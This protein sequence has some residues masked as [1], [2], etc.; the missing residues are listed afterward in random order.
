MS[1]LLIVWGAVIVAV[2]HSLELDHW[3]P[4]VV[5]ARAR[6]W[7]TGVTLR[8]AFSG[9]VAHLVSTTLIGLVLILFGE[10]LKKVFEKGLQI[11]IGAVVTLIGLF[12]IQ[13]GFRIFRQKE[14]HA[15]HCGHHEKTLLADEGKGSFFLGA[16]YGLRPCLEAMPIF[17]SASRLGLKPALY[18]VLG[19]ALASIIGMVGI[20]WLGTV[21]L[22]KIRV[23]K[24][25]RYNELITGLIITAI[26]I[27]A[28]IGVG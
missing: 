10:G 21:C 11:G 6:R 26:G 22:E 14:S 1:V 17:I 25:E 18:T 3:M 27:Y 8:M 12:F 7:K 15:E 24:L 5:T 16:V 20:V 4:Y 13:R 23:E 2:L 28:I 9:A 19:W